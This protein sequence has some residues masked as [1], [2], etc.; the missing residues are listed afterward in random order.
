MNAARPI[1]RGLFGNTGALD[2]REL[3][4]R[5]QTL[6]CTGTLVLG[7]AAHLAPGGD[8]GGQNGARI[9]GGHPRG[10]LHPQPGT[11][12]LLLI[13]KGQVQASHKLGSYDHLDAPGQ[14]FRFDPHAP[15][16]TPQLASVF[17]G[18]AVPAL[19]ALPRLGPPHE[20]LPG[21][22][23]LRALIRRLE[24]DAFS[25]S[26]SL[27][28]GGTLERALTLFLEGRAVAA[29]FERDDYRLD[30]ND[31]LR[32]VYRYSLDESRAPLLLEPLH[33]L[34]VRSLLGMAL[35]RPAGEPNLAT[36]SGLEAS[37]TGYHFY[38]NGLRFLHVPA[39]LVGIGRRYA[40]LGRDAP[41]PEL[42][43]PDDPPG[44]EERRFALTLRGQDA[45]NP[46]T[47]LSMAFAEDYGDSGRRI[48]DTLARGRN[49]EQAAGDLGLDL[50][51]LKPWLQ[52]LEQEGLIRPG[53]K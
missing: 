7:G 31:A 27:G 42:T 25:G 33:P 51:E 34:L 44:W 41:L 14:R 30:R 49:I 2:G 38:R 47:E 22:V 32:A 48:L 8:D 4:E 52:R 1:G 45:L 20:L 10:D 37:E 6:N 9:G 28:E 24:R 5:L 17:P 15:S 23:D 39:E 19:R 18:S 53:D 29:W 21:L 26:L 16:E 40:L 11:G 35:A 50:Q 43:L 36:Y 12:V 13:G 46:M 3:L